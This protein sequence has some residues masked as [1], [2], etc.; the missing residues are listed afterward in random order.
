MKRRN[1]KT[2]YPLGKLYRRVVRG[3]SH[4]LEGKH[5]HENT[6]RRRLEMMRKLLLFL[7][8]NH[9]QLRISKLRY[10]HVQAFLFTLRHLNNA[11]F[12][13][14]LCNLRDFIAYLERHHRL[15][16]LAQQLHG[17]PTGELLPRNIPLEQMLQICTPTEAELPRLATSLREKR[18]Q[19]I[20]EF[21][22]S[23]GVR[24]CELRQ[25]RIGELSDDLAKC[26][27][28]TRKG[29]TNR[30][31]FLGRP[32]VA[33]LVDY[34]AARGVDKRRD[35]N[36]YIFSAKKDGSSPLSCET[37]T[38][39]VKAYGIL[40]AKCPITPHCIRHTFATEML[41]RTHCL[42]TVQE[43]LGHRS[44][45]NTMRYCGLDFRDTLW[46]VNRYHPHGADCQNHDNDGDGNNA[47]DANDSHTCGEA[48]SAASNTSLPTTADTTDTLMAGKRGVDAAVIDE[49]TSTA[50]RKNGKPSG[51]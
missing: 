17:K 51:K 13:L 11:S 20:L 23:T 5:Y 43:Y 30:T 35:R 10:S 19:A 16:P 22:F 18:N 44:I 14:Y 1:R 24:S 45:N 6:Q 21:L 29:G 48:V 26:R 7:Y 47:N 38:K 4:Y 34:F 40:R 8:E 42:R 31:V 15:P 27:I 41:R 3:Y 28:A 37:V 50:R 39:M 46:A 33:A 36:A 25:A 2:P 12:N 49:A 32:A 9:P